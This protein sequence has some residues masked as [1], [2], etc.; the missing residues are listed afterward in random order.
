MIWADVST[1]LRRDTD[2]RPLYFLTAVLD[3]TTRKLADAELRASERKFRE[4]IEAFDEGYFSVTLDGVLLDHNPAYN[5][6]LGLDPDADL[7][8]QHTPNF[9]QDPADR[10]TYVEQLA[11]GRTAVSGH[12]ARA[13]TGDGTPIVVLS[14]P[15]SCTARAP[16]RTST[17]AC[18]D[19][20]ARKAAEEE[21]AAPQR[22][23]RAARR[24]AHRAARGRQQGA[25]GLRLLRVARPARAAA[26]HQRVLRACCRAVA[27]TASTTK[28]AT[29]STSSPS[30]CARWA[31]SSTTCCSSR[32]SAAPR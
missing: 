17:A 7:R 13:R 10:E 5:R 1:R 6:I 23:A 3:I 29:T 16:S 12:L 30:R 28:G 32:A 14:A 4:T 11:A 9:W 22:R 26:P 21:V 19:F 25:R 15:T 18:V 8:G 31:C 2:G 20:T 27:R 24:R